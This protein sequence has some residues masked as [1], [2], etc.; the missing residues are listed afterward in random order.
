MH[1]ACPLVLRSI[2]TETEPLK[3]SLQVRVQCFAPPQITSSNPPSTAASH[4]RRFR[5]RLKKAKW[6][7]TPPPHAFI[8]TFHKPLREVPATHRDWIKMRQVCVPN[9]PSPTPSL[10]NE[11]KRLIHEALCRQRTCFPMKPE[12]GIT[13]SP[14]TVQLPYHNADSAVTTRGR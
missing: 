8:V 1:R 6:I 11:L 3:T 10:H 13:D 7:C 9:A 14:E 4:L 2:I 5:S 12:T